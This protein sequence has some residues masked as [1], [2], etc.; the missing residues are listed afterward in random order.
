MANIYKVYIDDPAAG[1]VAVW[2]ME[3]ASPASAISKVMRRV[4]YGKNDRVESFEVSAELEV[5]NM[6]YAEYKSRRTMLALDTATPS[7]NG[8]A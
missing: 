3:A 1:D 6:T 7:D 2:T 5:R 4:S 8:G